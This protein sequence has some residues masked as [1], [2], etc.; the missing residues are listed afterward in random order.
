MARAKRIPTMDDFHRLIRRLGRM[1][2]A[3]FTEHAPTK[4]NRAGWESGFLDVRWVGDIPNNA[5]NWISKCR[6]NRPNSAKLESVRTTDEFDALCDQVGK[7]RLSLFTPLWY[8]LKLTVYSDA[9]P[10]VT[11]DENPECCVDPLW[12]HS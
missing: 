12:F 11:F 2:A 6:F 8:G 7:L 1:L 5:Q 10:V 9:K 4:R 3:L